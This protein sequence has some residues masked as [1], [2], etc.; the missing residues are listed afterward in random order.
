M[1]F[2][3]EGQKDIDRHLYLSIIKQN[4]L[5]NKYRLSVYNSDQICIGLK[6]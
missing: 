4:G 1:I 6:N 5:L 2:E 3:A